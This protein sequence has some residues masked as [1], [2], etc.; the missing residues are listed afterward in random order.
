M[1]ASTEASSSIPA[2]RDFFEKLLN[3]LNDMLLE[4]VASKY[5]S[6]AEALWPV[7]V[8]LMLAWLVVQCLRI[9]L[10]PNAEQ[11]LSSLYGKVLKMMMISTIAFSWSYAYRYVA[12][13]IMNGVPELIADMTGSSSDTIVLSFVDNLIQ[14]VKTSIDTFSE[15]SIS[16]AIGAIFVAIIMFVV[17]IA[18]MVTYFFILIEAKLLIA[19]LLILTPVFLTC[20][21]FETTRTYFFN[22]INAMFMP[23]MTLLLLNLI[24]SLM[25]DLVYRIFKEFFVGQELETSLSGAVMGITVGAFMWILIKKAPQ[26]ASNLVSNGFGLGSG[27]FNP[28]QKFREH[29][30]KKRSQQSQVI[31]QKTQKIQHQQLVD[32]IKSS[33]PKA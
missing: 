20:L 16:G 14:S 13:P 5:K 22:W 9:I 17:A 26:Y 15:E 30:D 3:Q 32:A 12:D 8:S 29:T 18:V 27:G 1:S 24:V 23:L 21:M 31:Q 19:L 2:I 10:R 25:G 6:V 7:V 33:H 11:S 4:G 28:I